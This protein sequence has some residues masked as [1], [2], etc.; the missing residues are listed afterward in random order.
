MSNNDLFE[1]IPE[2]PYATNYRCGIVYECP[3]L[4]GRRYVRFMKKPNSSAKSLVSLSYARYL[5]Q[6]HLWKKGFGWIPRDKE[7]DHINND[8]LDDRIENYQLLSHEFNMKKMNSFRGYGAYVVVCVCCGKKHIV[9][10]WHVDDHMKLVDSPAMCCS[11]TCARSIAPS[12]KLIGTTRE[13]VKKYQI[14]YEIKTHDFEYAD[15]YGNYY[16]YTELIDIRNKDLINYKGIDTLRNYLPKEL[17][18]IAESELVAPIDKANFIRDYINEGKP[19]S[20]IS[21]LINLHIDTIGNYIRKYK[22]P[23]PWRDKEEERIEKIVSLLKEGKSPVEISKICNVHENIARYHAQ[24]NNIQT[25]EKIRRN[26]TM[27]EIPRLYCEEGK[28]VNELKEMFSLDQRQVHD[29]LR[30]YATCPYQG[31]ANNAISNNNH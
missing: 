6:V 25:P 22:I 7:V 9:K 12:T 11:Y 29:A 15:Y 4:F 23:T 18:M 26:I 19:I 5:Y 14:L 24:R 27:N 2:E 30:R 20:V 8:F 28:S 3:D 16:P 1:F 10:K 13:W 21:Q 31:Q 17:K